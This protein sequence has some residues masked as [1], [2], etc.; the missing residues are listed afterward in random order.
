MALATE[1]RRAARGRSALAL[2]L[3]ALGLLVSPA[4]AGAT[5]NLSGVWLNSAYTVSAYQ[6]HMSADGQTLT[7]TWNA[8]V[9]NLN[10]GLLGSFTG[11]L[12]ESGT[13]FTG[14]MHVTVGSLSVGGT[15]TVTIDAEQEFGYPTLS[16]SYEEDDGF[17]GSFTLEIW[18]L[19][20][21]VST[22]PN[23]TVSF[24]FLCPGPR[25]CRDRAEVQRTA[26]G[27]SAIVGS[28]PFTIEAGHTRKVRL[29]LDQ[30]G[31]KLLAKGGSLRVQVLVLSLTKPISLPPLTKLWTG[32]FRAK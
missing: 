4:R 12:N 11:T 25:T 26:T 28:V 14:H 15:M 3:L 5:Q 30:A 32:T 18:L 17:S 27:S 10:E 1:W 6:L 29:S 9:G 31:R 8:N 7:A 16:V 23:P 19:P 2:A 22:G 20:T 13:A 21:T 24:E